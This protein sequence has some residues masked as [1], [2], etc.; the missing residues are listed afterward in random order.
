[1]SFNSQ[2]FKNQRKEIKYLKVNGRMQEIFNYQ[3]GWKCRII[4]VIIM[5]IEDYFKYLYKQYHHTSHKFPGINYIIYMYYILY[6]L[7]RNLVSFI[8]PCYSSVLGVLHLQQFSSY[9]MFSTSISCSQMCSINEEQTWTVN[10]TV[11]LTLTI[12]IHRDGFLTWVMHHSSSKK[13]K[14]MK[15]SSRS[16]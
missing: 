14:I 8:M 4:R 15:L 12:S 6:T 13:R 16:I 10:D 11:F 3:L 5:H 9:C 2:N 7:F 1:M